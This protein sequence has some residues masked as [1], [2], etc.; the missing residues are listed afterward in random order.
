VIDEGLD[1]QIVSED[2][3][4]EHLVPLARGHDV[5]VTLLTGDRFAAH[6]PD[7]EV[8][9]DDVEL[10]GGLETDALGLDLARRALA[11]VVGHEV[12]LRYARQV[13]GQ[14]GSAVRMRRLR[15]TLGRRL[16]LRRRALRVV[17][18]RGE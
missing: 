10:L 11:L 14:L 5:L 8:R 9:G 13:S 12:V 6:L 7:D 18:D 1:E 15:S 4:V 17:G 3:A 16:A 2:A